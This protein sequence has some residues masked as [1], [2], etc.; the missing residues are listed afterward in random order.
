MI[1]RILILA[2]CLFLLTGACTGCSVQHWRYEELSFTL[3]GEFQNCS[4]ESYAADFDFLFDNGTVAIAGIRETKQALQIFGAT[5]AKTYAQ[6]VIDYN[7]L[8]CQPTQQDGLWCFSYE[9]VSH[10]TPM[11]YICTVYEA[12][13]S[14]WQI[15]AYCET[16]N[17]SANSSAMWSLISSMKTP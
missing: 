15:Q 3:P 12:Q 1:R 8:T 10:G 14:F 6:L 4:G 17:Y 7:Q 13:Q 11:T 16:A 5:D 9:A 2:L